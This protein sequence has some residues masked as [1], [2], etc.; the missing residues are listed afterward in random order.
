MKLDLV[1]EEQG[2]DAGRLGKTRYVVCKDGG[3]KTK[4]SNAC[5][6]HAASLTSGSSCTHFLICPYDATLLSPFSDSIMVWQ[7]YARSSFAA[8]T[9][10]PVLS[11][12]N[13]FTCLAWNF[14]PPTSHI[15]SRWFVLLLWST[16]RF[17]IA[18]SSFPME[19]Q[20]LY[21]IPAKCS[22]WGWGN[23]QS[24]QSC[25]SGEFSWCSSTDWCP[26]VQ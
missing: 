16:S 5:R 25:C 11:P 14:T 7:F 1:V 21:D 18:D 2:W 10:Y 8:T 23:Q 3:A 15:V 17:D 19:E 13:S 26:V 22:I 6:Q 4:R 9:F 24:N 20:K 12:F